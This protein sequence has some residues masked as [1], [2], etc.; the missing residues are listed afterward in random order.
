MGEVFMM[1]GTGGGVDV[2]DATTTTDKVL[3][4]ETFYSNENEGDS[5]LVGTMPNNGSLNPESLSA[6][7]SYTIPKGYTDGGIITVKDLASQ[8]S[9]TAIASS[10]LTGETAW[11]N[12]VKI[13]GTVPNSEIKNNGSVTTSDSF[14]LGLGTSATISSGYV[15]STKTISVPTLSLDSGKSIATAA[16]ML[17][18]YQ[19]FNTSGEK[20]SG[21]MVQ[22][23]A[24]D[25]T[26]SYGGSQSY[27]AGYYPSKWTVTG[28][29]T[30]RGAR[31]NFIFTGGSK[32]TNSSGYGDFSI[33]ISFG[34][35]PTYLA[36]TF[37][38]INGGSSVFNIFNMTVSNMGTAYSQETNG[39]KAQLVNVT[40]N[41]CTLRIY[42][43]N[44]NQVHASSGT[45]YYV[46]C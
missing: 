7:D 12:G 29:T 13:V 44:E 23:S 30:T 41:G 1:G 6:G 35:T 31:G 32:N 19:A 45:A 34:F 9:A 11:V 5:V 26:L 24:S 27:S 43:F 21:S 16:S 4:G 33:T 37:P 42:G 2:S 38:Q 3:S 25:T 22:R 15:E 40:S 28:G 18:G 17:S 10:I 20:I 8:T 14:T 39:L 36:I 46:A